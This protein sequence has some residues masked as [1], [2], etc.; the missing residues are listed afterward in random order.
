MRKQTTQQDM[1]LLATSNC[2]VKTSQ[3]GTKNVKTSQHGTK[4]VKTSQHG[5]KNVKTSQ[6]GTKNVKTHSSYVF[7][8]TKFKKK[9][10]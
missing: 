5:T 1:S 7:F 9:I 10:K 2:R 8:V 4:N 6:H 3:H